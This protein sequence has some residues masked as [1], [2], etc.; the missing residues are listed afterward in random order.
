[1]GLDISSPHSTV[2]FFLVDHAQGG[3]DMEMIYPTWGDIER[4]CLTL[5]DKVKDYKPDVLVGISRGGLVPV[6]LL[7]DVLDNFNIAIMK[8][9][10]YKSMGKTERAPVITQ[11]LNVDLK[12]KKVLIV[13]DVAD[14]GSSLIA[15]R[16][17]VK[18]LG[19]D[20]IRI[21]TL[22]YKPESKLKPDFFIEET[23]AWV[24]YPWERKE[25]EREMEKR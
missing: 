3:F 8:I 17:H 18:N 14:T 24:V 25:A 10:F 7:S 20:E 12:G 13:D 9:E 4:M 5:A 1:M 21:A 6:R 2:P 19:A 16:D 23:E 15:A 22:H 11:P